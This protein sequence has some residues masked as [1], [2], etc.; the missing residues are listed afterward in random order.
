MTKSDKKDKFIAFVQ[1][2]DMRTS[3]D[4]QLKWNDIRTLHIQPKSEG[5]T[6]QFGYNLL[7]AIFPN[8]NT[9]RGD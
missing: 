1:K 7:Y 8:L 3:L 4:I 6:N 5:Y 9:L 2:M